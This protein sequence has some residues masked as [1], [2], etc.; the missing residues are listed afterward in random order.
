MNQTSSTFSRQ[1]RSIAAA[2][3]R[4]ELAVV[5]GLV[6]LLAGLAIA[7][8]RHT[9]SRSKPNVCRG[10]L[11]QLGAAMSIYSLSCDTKL[12]YASLIFSNRSQTTWDTLLSPIL[13]SEMKKVIG[14]PNVAA[15]S[16]SAV[17][18]LLL[19]PSDTIPPAAWAQKYKLHRRTYSITRH[20]MA[21]A[22]WPP[23]PGNATG[24]GLNWTFGPFGTNPPSAKIYSTSTNRQA[25]VRL[26]MILKPAETLLL[27]EH[28]WTN[29]IVANGAGSWIDRT[30]DHVEQSRLPAATYHSGRFNYLKVDGHVDL[31]F[32]DE[33]V[34]TNGVV[35]DDPRRHGGMWTIRAN[36]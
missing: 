35:G 6:V 10:N 26:G 27:A 32:P 34:G 16:Q 17:N 2:F 15:P 33:T 20:N 22:N 3:T 9:A 14:D 13:R 25:S 28:A 8:A 36:D 30:G 23:G 12:P 18:H 31:M 4:V 29:N 11:R 21:L 24:I 5:I 1:R 19:C 7:F